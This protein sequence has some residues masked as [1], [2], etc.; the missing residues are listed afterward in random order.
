MDQYLKSL[1]PA[2]QA[3]LTEERDLI[4]G[5]VPDTVETMRYRMPT[6]DYAGEMPCAFGSQKRYMSLYM[7]TEIVAR[8]KPELSH[9]SLGKSCIRFKKIEELPPETIKV[10]LEET[11]RIIESD[12]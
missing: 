5:A 10:M 7:D 8:N 6:Y 3:P 12:A 1:E 4:L 9:L 2:R 11:V